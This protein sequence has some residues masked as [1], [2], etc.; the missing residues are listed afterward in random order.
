MSQ[1]DLFGE[2]LYDG[3]AGYENPGYLSEQL[4]T[5]LGNKRLLLPLISQAVDRA[6]K[7]LGRS[8]LAIADLFSGSGV[9]ARLFKRYADRLVANDLEPYAE[10]INRCYLQNISELD[11]GELTAAYERLRARLSG[12]LYRDGVI[13][14]HYAP[15]D[16]KVIRP[17]ERVFYT[18]RNA[19]YLD[20]ARRLIGELPARLQPLLLGPLLSEA[21]VHANTAGVF[22]GFYKNSATG[23]G[24][25][26]GR[27]R[28]ALTRIIG[29]IELRFP[30]FSRYEQEVAVYCED[31]NTL[32]RR[33]DELDLAYID[34]PYNQHPYGSN[35]FMLNLLTNYREPGQISRVS[36][37]PTNWR[38]SAYNVRRRAVETLGELIENTPAKTVLVSFNSEGFVS[39]DHLRQ[40]LSHRGALTVFQQPYNAF[41]GSRNLR[42]R[43]LHVTEYMFYLERA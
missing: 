25:F 15:R 19:R 30:V 8:S 43:P 20:T 21:S 13:A 35:Y 11:L 27:N 42:G 28:D 40:L 39:Y 14:R 24:Q 31:A 23:V 5:Y 1:N 18:T 12:E 7:R 26:G 33:L 9:V 37:I 2:L 32:V 41:R 34:P 10:V 16:D 17:G 36:G 38:R 4:I 29:E 6:R 22:K 3:A